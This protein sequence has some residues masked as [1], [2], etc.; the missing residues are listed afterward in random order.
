[1]AKHTIFVFPFKTLFLTLGG[2]PLNR[3]NAKGIAEQIADKIRASEQMVIGIM[4]EGTRSKVEKWKSGFL[5][6]ARAADCPVLLAS[7]DFKNKRIRFGEMINAREDVDQQ[8]VEIKDY[9]R[10]FQPKFPEKF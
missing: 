10:Q 3:G 4:P 2:I 9:Y 7:L 8:L 1:L 5:R 6:I